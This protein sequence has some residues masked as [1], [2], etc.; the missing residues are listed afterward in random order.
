MPFWLSDQHDSHFLACLRLSAYALSL[1]TEQGNFSFQLAGGPHIPLRYG[2][3]DAATEEECAPEGRLP[4]MCTSSA[5]HNPICWPL[6]QLFSSELLGDAGSAPVSVRPAFMLQVCACEIYT[7]DPCVS[8]C[9]RWHF[10]R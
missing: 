10:M 3:T 1:F 8:S 5:Y 9:L 2:R 6:T 4:G 7:A